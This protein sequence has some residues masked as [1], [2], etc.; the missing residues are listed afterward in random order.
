MKIKNSLYKSFISLFLLQV[1]NY[2]FPLLTWPLLTNYLGVVHFG[3]FMIILSIC[4]ISNILTDFGFNLSA[5]H[6]ISK[7]QTNLAF[8]SELFSC[9]YVLK[10][11]IA[12]VISIISVLYL[13]FITDLDAMGGN[14]FTILI[15]VLILFFQSW[16][17]PWLFQGIEKMKNITKTIILSKIIYLVLIM[18][19]VSYFLSINSALF[20]F[21]INQ[22]VVSGFYIYFSYKEKIYFR[23]FNLSIMLDELKYSFTFFISRVAVSVYTTSN[24]LVLGYFHSP[25]VVGLYASAEKLYSAGTGVASVLSQAMYPYTAR[26]GNLSFLIKV[27]IGLFIP[28]V[29]GC[30]VISYFSY[31]IMTIV[32][33]S[34]FY[35][36]GELLNY[37]LF[38]MCIT[39]LSVSIGY[40]GFAAINKIHLANYSVLVGA[41]VHLIGLIIL[42]LNDEITSLNVLR[43]VIITE[44][45]ILFIRIFFLKIFSKGE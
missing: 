32:F 35:N 9:I 1:A 21:L 11:L 19:L 8:I 6:K 4:M 2:I 3:G 14:K 27:V 43:L 41:I 17:C 16:Q 23:K 22:V 39:F 31:D 13:L 34:E 37:F 10:T 20:C 15:V 44:F 38:L 28:F 7:N 26:T 24:T 12:V 40:P 33:G 42:Y 30:Y 18:F 5:T 36:G 45:L 25:Q 29:I